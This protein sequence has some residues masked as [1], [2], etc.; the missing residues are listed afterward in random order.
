[1]R[2]KDGKVSFRHFPR[3]QSFEGLIFPNKPL[4]CSSQGD[5]SHVCVH[6]S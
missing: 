5:V 2:R 3:L 6:E 1:M 4:L